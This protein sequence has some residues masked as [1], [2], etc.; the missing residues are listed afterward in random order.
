MKLPKNLTRFGFVDEKDVP[1]YDRIPPKKELAELIA[2]I[3]EHLAKRKTINTSVSSYG[4][5]HIVERKIRK[6]VANGDFI[7]AMIHCGFEYKTYVGDP[8]CFFN[9]S[10]KNLTQLRKREYLSDFMY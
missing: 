2:F 1:N 4:M 8:N 7:A 10:A 9:V 5:K 6:Y 3:D